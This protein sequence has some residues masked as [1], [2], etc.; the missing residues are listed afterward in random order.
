MQ[1]SLGTC[2]SLA[3]RKL[4]VHTHLVPY[5]DVDIF[6]VVLCNAIK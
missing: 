2:Y 1:L 5:S 3:G 6:L 4:I